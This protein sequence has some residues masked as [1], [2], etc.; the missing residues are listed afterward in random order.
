MSPDSSPEGDSLELR[1]ISTLDASRVPESRRARW[2]WRTARYAAW[3][4]AILLLGV[5]GSWTH[6]AVES[7]LRQLRADS[8]SS[9]LD[10]QVQA[11][12]VWIA[13]K[14]LAARR[15]ARDTRLRESVAALLRRAP[16]SPCVSLEDAGLGQPL[17]PFLREE[18]I[19]AFHVIDPE[20]RIIAASP[21]TAC[22]ARELPE[23]LRGQA[24]LALDGHMAFVR[25]IRDESAL[26]APRPGET[27][28]A[29]V[30][31]F[32]PVTDAAGRNLAAIALGK[33]AKARF[34]GILGAA[35]TGR[36]GEVFAFDA[37][38]FMLSESRFTS[39]LVERGLLPRSAEPSALLNVALRVPANTAD[40]SE[41]RP[42]TRL[43]ED[44]LAGALSV[45]RRN[46]LLEPYVNYRGERVIGAWRWLPEYGM[47]VAAELAADEAYAPLA[48]LNVA[49]TLIFAAVVMAMGTALL[50]VMW[51]KRQMG[52]A[53]RLGAYVLERKIGAGG[54]ANVYLAR[55]ALLRRPTAVKILRPERSTEQFVARF[56]REVKLASQLTH[57]NTVEIYDY[58]R[59]ADGLFYY[60]MEY[61]EGV[62]LLELLK[63]GAV[64][65]GRT[66]YLLRQVCAGL[67]EAHAKGLVHRDIKPENL[68]ICT[69]GG[70]FDVVKILDF[71]LVKSVTEPQTRDLTRTIKFLGT[72]QYMAPERFRSPSDVDARADIYSL[73]AVAFYML[74]GRELFQ[75]ADDLELANRVL[76]DEVPRPATVA[77]QAIPVEL[78]LLV[79]ACLEK[80]REDRP[81][82]VTDLM[83]AFDAL[84][85][86]CRW[87]QRDAADWWAK[88]TVN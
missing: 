74:T 66:I 80:R 75:G 78:D 62:E 52:R 24:A 8:L 57:P 48:F 32:T 86:T 19:A 1:R 9:V 10:A 2:S 23:L 41:P 67:A 30:W 11:I 83:E 56:E 26:A 36:S 84:A 46:V 59:T 35:Q 16:A 31:F 17:D 65:V 45:P 69:H 76:N 73:G 14:Q 63:E 3:G 54:M 61:L 34:A 43:A 39:D 33:Y 5:L 71:G 79:A 7:S 88:R 51:L 21:F 72:P 50:Y 37:Q 4:I 13:E 38:G 15:L 12:E 28:P 85:V 82:R 64:P 22:A 47:G 18:A 87:T 55:H 6:H 68:M 29:I 20:G 44:A 42:L 40:S 53:H 49:F 77:A 60:A 27:S 70:E 58:G 81:Q 25:P